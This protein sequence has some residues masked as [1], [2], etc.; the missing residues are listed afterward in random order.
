LG[1][2]VFTELKSAVTPAS[3]DVVVVGA[4]LAGIT[5][6]KKLRDKG[7]RVVVLEARGRVGG[8]L[9]TARNWKGPPVD[10]GAT[11]IHDYADNPLY[12]LAEKLGLKTID[13]PYANSVFIRDNGVVLDVAEAAALVAANFTAVL[14][15]VTTY[16]DELEGDGAP[17]PGLQDG[18][19][20]VLAAQAP[21]FTPD[22][23]L[24]IS[25]P[26]N[27]LIKLGGGAE[28][29]QLSLYYYGD[30]GNVVGPLDRLFAQGF[31]QM[32]RI[33]ARGLDVRRNTVVKEITYDSGS[34]QV[35]TNR[36]MF[37]AKR[38]IVT[39]PISVLKAGKIRFHPGLPTE[40]TAAL[41]RLG[42]GTAMKFYLMFPRAFWEP[43]SELV[44]DP[45]WLFRLSQPAEPWVNWF[46]A[47]PFLKQPVLMAFLDGDFARAMD[48]LTDAEIAQEATA[49]LR[50]MYGR[51]TLQPLA[52]VRSPW[53][54]D[55]YAMGVY[56]NL[57]PGATPADFDTVGEPVGD[58]LFFAGDGTTSLFPG[59]T[60]A[61]YLTGLRA[62]NL[63]L[64]LAG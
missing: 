3:L 25:T 60:R 9:Y 10:L 22:E 28:L 17:D 37:Q 45:T 46:N 5:A 58:T 12:P 29:D 61:A 55:P 41:G 39:A 20:T 51:K 16:A 64:G 19:D 14:S 15:A 63:I 49:V 62:A 33:L 35:A 6:A 57:P 13:T 11:W 4:G 44:P 40:K 27:T 23:L 50:R 47:A 42:F 56:P 26:T 1:P 18:F 21:P 8:R 32:P 24:G 31:D 30:D 59:N 52:Y 38:V 53:I 54:T 36:G 7:K 43:A 2:A 48:K 34:V